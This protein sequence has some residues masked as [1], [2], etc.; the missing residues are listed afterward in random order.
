MGVVQRRLLLGCGDV[1]RFCR[2]RTTSQHS[3]NLFQER[4]LQCCN[5]HNRRLLNEMNYKN[6][7]QLMKNMHARILKPDLNVIL[8]KRWQHGGSSSEH[9]MN[10]F[11]RKT[12]QM[13]RD[14]A[15]MADNVDVYDYLKDEVAY[16]LVDRLR[17]VTRKFDVALDL[18][19]GRG[20]LAKYLN[21][22]LVS[23][24]YQCE[25]SEKMLNQS[26]TCEDV[27]TI[28]VQA[29]EEFIPFQ[30][31][32]L[33]LVLSSLSLHWINDLPGTLHQIHNC[34]KND[35]AFIGVMFGG[36][37]LFELRCSLQ[38]A[39]LEREG[40]FAPHVSPFTDIRDLGSL[41]NRAGFT[42]LT[43]DVDEIKVNYPSMF[44]VMSDLKGMAE[45]NASWSRKLILH[46]DTLA[47]ASA[48]YK[49]MYGNDDGTVPAT[50]ELYFMIGWKPDQS[51]AKP[52]SRGSA[53][54]SLKDIGNLQS[55][56]GKQDKTAE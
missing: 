31:N 45:S 10:V 1:T 38:L 41:L 15:A 36:D 37:T 46:R 18:S 56:K 53:K 34:L 21:E 40:G 30:E 32:S 20:H 35:G 3:R 7:F 23:T 47:A 22:E 6:Y 55:K 25:F 28:K 5:L 44:E 33:D 51:Q 14:R 16:R 50:F 2:T 19:C 43:V 48:I 52:A 11:D 49:E 9:T 27:E 4:S 8:R 42:L 54:M 39:E 13:Q 26:H 17:D 29:D 24:L 12:K